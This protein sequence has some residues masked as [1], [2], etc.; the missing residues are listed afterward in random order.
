MVEAF[1]GLE[2]SFLEDRTASTEERCERSKGRMMNE[3][4]RAL[5]EQ[6]VTSDVYTMEPGLVFTH[7]A[8]DLKKFAEL[9][10]KECVLVC[11]DV[12]D[13]ADVM[14]KSKLVTDAGRMLNE[15]MWGGAQN[16]V[17]GIKSQFGIE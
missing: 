15:G 16:C 8:I 2:E 1:A 9:I 14:S 7:G 17:T 4:I 12:S 5:V 13:E 6:A 10:I 3:R 11:E